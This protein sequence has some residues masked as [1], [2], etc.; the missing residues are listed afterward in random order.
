MSELDC[1]PDALKF[2]GEYSE[3]KKLF[4]VMFFVYAS[5]RTRTNLT[6]TFKII[7]S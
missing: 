4:P 2:R 5:K 7:K 3:N 6:L 1:I